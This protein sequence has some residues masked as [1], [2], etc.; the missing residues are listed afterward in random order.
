MPAPTVSTDILRTLHRIHRQLSDLRE[1]LARGPK[2]IAAAEANLANRQSLLEAAK[3]DELNF[4]KNVDGK[5]LQL[6]TSE[7]RIKEF[8]T[9]RNTSQSNRE[10]QTFTEQINAAEMANSVL[11]DEILEAMEETQEYKN[12]TVAAEAD[13]AAAKQRVAEVRAMVAEQE[14]R[15]TA[16]KTRLETELKEAEIALPPEIRDPYQR[17]VKHLGEDAL[18]PLDNQYCGGCNQQI[19]LNVYSQIMMNQPTFC[20][21]CGRLLYLKEGDTAALKTEA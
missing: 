9:K 10:Y 14:P 18:A 20:K 12:K 16:D 19:P 17:V 2:Q 7:G 4:R 8:Q 5:Q 13:L 15:L 3:L 1:R 6:K 21:T 11:M